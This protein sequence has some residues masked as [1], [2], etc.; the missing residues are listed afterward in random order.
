MKDIKLISA[1]VCGQLSYIG[2]PQKDLA[3]RIGI[4]K[5]TLCE[6]LKH[7]ETFTVAELLRIEKVIG[8]E[9]LSET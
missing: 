5:S 7:P 8:K 3:E 9:V 1:N 6:K 2:M 4:H